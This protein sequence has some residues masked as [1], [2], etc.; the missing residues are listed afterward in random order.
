M[1]QVPG[2]AVVVENLQQLKDFVDAG[3]V[4]ITE[5]TEIFS[6][7]T[8]SP[9]EYEELIEWLSAEM[10]AELK[11]HRTICSQVASRHRLLSEFATSHDVIVFVSGKTS[12]N[13]KVLR[14]LCLKCN[15]RTYHVSSP[16]GLDPGWFSPGDTVGVSG[17][18][19]TPKWLLDKVAA[20]IENLQ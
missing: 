13:G 8:K 18:T 4:S 12:S 17:A 10:S 14:D 19:S 2:R 16:D 5:A 3:V 9:V 20:A 1:G 6:Q 7:T 15:P 11:A